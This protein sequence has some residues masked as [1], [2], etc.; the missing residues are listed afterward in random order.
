M[1]KTRYVALLKGVNVGKAKRLAMAD[2]RDLLDRLGYADVVTYL[3]SGNV[4]FTAPGSAAAVTT[5]VQ[6]S[7]LS[8]LKLDVA[9]VIR[10]RAQLA[11]AIDADPF[12]DLADDPAKHLLGFF[13]AVPAAAR[14]SA[15]GEFL[16]A[17]DP[18][19]DVVGSYRIDRDHCYLWCPQGVQKSLFGTVDWDG[20]LGVTVTMRNW[21]TA[22]KLLEIS[23]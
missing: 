14:L 19:P 3:Q 21:T 15:F 12:A 1:A 20:K 6:A 22:L 11:E 18:D 7:L 23:A 4:A 9:V 2:L 8:N 16:A 13:S 5:A 17:R 10:T